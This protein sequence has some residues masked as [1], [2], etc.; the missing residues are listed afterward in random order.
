M[1]LT[2]KRFDW[3]ETLDTGMQL[4]DD[5]HRQYARFVNAFLKACVRTDDPRQ[6]LEQAFSFLNAYAREHLRT[7]EELMKEYGYPQEK[8]HL[9]QHKYLVEWIDKT[10][11]EIQSK[12]GLN[13]D[14][15]LKINYVLVDWFQDHIRK[16]DRQLTAFLTEIAESRKDNR[17][18]RLIKDVFS[19]SE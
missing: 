16:V 15:V 13:S 12:Q 2:M 17:L 14:F 10:H 9:N 11:D 4:I 3:N 6:K 7:E 8:A 5:Q 18:L 1:Y 19:S